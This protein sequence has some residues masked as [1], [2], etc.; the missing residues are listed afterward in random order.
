MHGCRHGNLNCP[1]LRVHVI[2]PPICI[3][4]SRLAVNIC[5]DNR[6]LFDRLE[7]SGGLHFATPSRLVAERSPVCS[8]SLGIAALARQGVGGRPP[9][10]MYTPC[11]ASSRRS[12]PFARNSPSSLRAGGPTSHLLPTV[13]SK[14]RPP[15]LCIAVPQKIPPNQ[16]HSSFSGH[17]IVA[18]HRRTIH[19]QN[20]LARAAKNVKNLGLDT[21]LSPSLALRLLFC[22][23]RLNARP[24]ISPLHKKSVRILIVRMLALIVPLHS[25]TLYELW[26]LFLL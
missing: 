18:E 22:C 13:T 17:P 25:R 3:T 23:S 7:H 4:Q 1:K 26:R 21:S 15:E 20:C 24:L 10:R 9:P 12:P 8:P 16:L 14:S 11:T 2:C 6:R 19:I 5:T